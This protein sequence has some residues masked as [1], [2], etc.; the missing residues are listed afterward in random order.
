M[1]RRGVNPAPE[2]HLRILSVED[3]PLNRA[4]VRASLARAADTRLS[5]AELV[6]ASNL[7]EARRCLAADDYDLVLLDRRL[8]DGDGF[9]LANDLRADGSRRRPV[10]VALTAD[11]VAATH[12]AAMEAGCDAILIK[13]YRPPELVALLLEQL[14]VG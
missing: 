10:V 7:A 12:A 1:G 8:P 5:G 6:E 13:P 4:L 14:T 2:A 3:D 9:E 11:A